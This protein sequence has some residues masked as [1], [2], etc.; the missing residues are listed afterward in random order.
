MT[1]VLVTTL[2]DS[3]TARV[4]SLS[5]ELVGREVILQGTVTAKSIRNGHVFL[6]VNGFKAIVF[7]RD[8]RRLQTPYFLLEGDEVELAGQ[9]QD[10]EGQ[11]ELV[12]REV[13]P[14]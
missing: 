7:E 2:A 3:M 6:E 14:R 13:L 5:P 1:G 8:A 4:D 9:V 11:V 10:Y 12:V